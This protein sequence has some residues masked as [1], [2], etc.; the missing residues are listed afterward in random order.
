MAAG[1]ASATLILGGEKIRVGFELN[2][3]EVLKEAMVGIATMNDNTPATT[4][5]TNLATAA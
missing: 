4:Q 3:T 2:Y 1:F 5:R